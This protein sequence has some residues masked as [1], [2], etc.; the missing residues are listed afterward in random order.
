MRKLWK[1][2]YFGNGKPGVT[3]RLALLES[4]VAETKWVGRTL[5]ALALG[6]LVRVL[7]K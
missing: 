1:D 3:T 2:M 4:S 7:T 5:L 6:I